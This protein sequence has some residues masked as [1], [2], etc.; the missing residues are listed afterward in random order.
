MNAE[1]LMA[2]TPVREETLLDAFVDRG[3][4][5]TE[6]PILFNRLSGTNSFVILARTALL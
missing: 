3:S 1:P 5:E 4:G 6:L 2:T